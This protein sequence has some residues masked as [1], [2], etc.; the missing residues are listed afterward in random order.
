M[1]PPPTVQVGQAVTERNASLLF[2]GEL[3]NG[4]CDSDAN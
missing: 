1:T 3:D 2:S 4:H